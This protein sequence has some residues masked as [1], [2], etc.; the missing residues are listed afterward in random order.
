MLVAAIPPANGQP[1]SV[2]HSTLKVI[3]NEL[4]IY[5]IK[6]LRPLLYFQQFQRYCCW[7][8]KCSGNITKGKQTKNNRQKTVK[9]LLAQHQPPLFCN[10]ESTQQPSQHK[11]Y[12]VLRLQVLLCNQPILNLAKMYQ[13]W[14]HQF[15]FMKNSATKSCPRQHVYMTLVWLF[16]WS[17]LP[18]MSRMT[19]INPHVLPNP[20]Q[21]LQPTPQLFQSIK[22]CQFIVLSHVPIFKQQRPTLGER[23]LWWP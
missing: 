4:F 7:S 11:I 9:Q 2:W 16:L 19:M 20:H 1:K 13:N 3:I 21:S 22:K 6:Y 23:W 12:S 5:L 8:K 14:L 17:Q 15:D 10:P 18:P